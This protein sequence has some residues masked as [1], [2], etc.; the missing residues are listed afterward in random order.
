MMPAGLVMVLL[1]PVSGRML[2]RLGGRGTLLVG[3]GVMSVSYVFR[4]F[5]TGSVAGVVLGSSLVGVGAAISFAAMPTLIMANVPITESASANGLNSLMRAIGGS[6]ASAVLA[7]VLSS[8]TF[9]AQGEVLPSLSAFED[10]Y[11]ISAATSLVAVV[12]VTFISPRGRRAPSA[13]VSG[14]GAET[15]V[16]GRVSPGGGGVLDPGAIVTVTE[17]DG[18]PVDWARTDKEG[19][20]SVALPGS[21]RYL[22]V[23][24]ARGWSPRAEVVDFREG[25]TE[26]HVE[27][28][29]ELAL[30]GVTVR[31]GKPIAGSL[32]L[33]HQGTGEFVATCKSDDHGQF[34]FPLPPSG[35]YI[36]TA[37]DGP[38][39]HAYSR[40]VVVT[41]LA[42]HV[43]I[44]VGP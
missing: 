31:L 32:V 37:V 35:A 40:K 8:V 16:H 36:L 34:R 4:V 42:A 39:Q 2:D 21:G 29:E 28:T 30:T 6:M 13:T 15:V 44:E 41:A 1:S 5:A 26:L 9:A 38:G 11:W 17:L 43:V 23:A 22:V 25:D 3:A 7:A 12:L 18:D 24:N 10:M 14:E 20:Y 33:L 19:R 27:L